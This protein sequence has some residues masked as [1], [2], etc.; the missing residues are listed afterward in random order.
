[1]VKEL[2][3]NEHTAPLTYYGWFMDGLLVVD[4]ITNTK[5]VASIDEFVAQ[6]SNIQWAD[7][8]EFMRFSS[9][10]YGGTIIGAPLNAKPLS[11]NYRRDA[12]DAANLTAP[13][14]W[15]D[16]VL[17]A[18][19]LNSSDFNVD[20]TGDYSMC[21]ELKDC[22]WVG[23]VAVSAILATMT[24]GYQTGF[25]WDPKTMQDFGGSA[26][27][28]RT[29]ELIQELLPYSATSCFYLNPPF[30]EGRCAMTI[31]LEML[32][33]G[34]SLFTPL[35]S[36]IGTAMVPGSTRALNRQTG[37][38][39][40][41]MPV[42]CP[43]AVLERTYAGSEVLVNRAPHFSTG[44]W[45]GF[46]DARQT[47]VHQ[48]A[49][50]AFWSFMSEPAYSKQLAMS[51]IALGPYRKSHLDTSAQSLAA[52]G[53]A[54][55][56][57]VAT[58]DY[59]TIVGRSL[60][61][62]NFAM[63]LRTLGGSRYLDTFT[64]ALRNASGGMAPAQISAN[65][66]AEYTTI[67]A[68]SGPRDVAI[69]ISSSSS[70]TPIILGV[71]VPLVVVLSALLVTVLVMR[72]RRRSLF[73]GHW[74]PSPG[75]DTTLVV[76]VFKGLRVRAGMHSGVQ[77]V[78]MERNATSGRVVFGGMP[79]AVTKAIGDAGA[80]GMTLMT[81]E[82]FQRLHPDRALKG[83]LVL[84]MGEHGLKDDDL[85]SVCMYQAMERLAAFEP[86][87]GLRGMETG[88]MDAPIGTVTI[89]FANMD[90]LATLQAWNREQADVAFDAYA[91]VSKQLLHDSGG[92]LVELTSLGLC[93]AAFSHP[94]DAVAWGAGLIE[95][96]KHHEWGE[97]CEEVLLH[98]SAAEGGLAL[99]H[100][101]VL[102]RGPRLKV[103]IDIGKV[104]ADVSPVSGRMTYRGRVMNR[105][106]RIS[107]KASSGM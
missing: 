95:V 52:W 106:A 21:W 55:Y 11:L 61:H 57:Q 51:T 8:T 39:E 71:T 46:V 81:E 27:M 29:M 76:T 13:N 59:L 14:T 82:S 23:K 25:L 105:A 40:L 37:R 87:R 15:E 60:E 49:M 100:R 2:I 94:L 70:K 47:N 93:L 31:A 54:G 1:M 78:D 66:A 89:A 88:V 19:I 99:L 85:G 92:S 44:A 33:T 17:A 41:C 73:G 7:V 43:H 24:A 84:A 36:V 22:D 67:L 75:E 107:G 58:R 4:V 30:A 34:V 5:L 96:M 26:A 83:V 35:K 16:M 74:V 69:I 28:T 38:L 65:V 79:L 97:L 6:D 72:V 64:T 62:P 45:S 104:Q 86:L 50:Y 98:E 63:D 103:G 20:G 101:R 42:L 68:S 53:A 10:T 18:Q 90:G 3:F 80:G 56:D 9:S 12:F 48:Q 91:A 32:F 77:K 102:F